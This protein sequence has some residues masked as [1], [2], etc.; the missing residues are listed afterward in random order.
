M[1]RPT[2][3][4]ID[5]FPLDCQFDDK[6]EMLL[7][8]K[9]APGLAVLV[10][11]WQMIYS[12]NGYYIAN[13]HDLCLLIKRKIDV[14]VN[15]VMDCINVCLRR[16]IFHKTSFDTHQIL[17]SKAIQ[18]R[19]FDAA[20]KKKSV[21][22][23]TEYLLISVDSSNNV[24][25]VGINDVSDGGNATNVNVNVEVKVKEKVKVKV[26]KIM[27]SALDDARSVLDYLNQKTGKSFRP[28]ESNLKFVRAR[29]NE[30]H[31]EA[32]LKSIVDR[33]CVEWPEGG[34]MHQY[35][36]PAT[37]FN[38]E[39][40][41]QYAGELSRPSAEMASSKAVAE[42]LGESDVIEGSCDHDRIG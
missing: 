4:G 41:N 8:E 33:K 17:T 9:G 13:N 1:A 42:W 38:A 27:S 30:G 5:Y 26:E 2:K 36:R 34:K 22:A 37:L 12:N 14:D 19:Y 15:E 7:I 35:L 40:C 23:V 25:S 18:K 21:I 24:V 10:T 28:V 29:I 16:G 11:I 20:K 39:K 32:V 3:Q 31:T 6:I